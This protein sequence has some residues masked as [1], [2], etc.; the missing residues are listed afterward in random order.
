MLTPMVGYAATALGYVAARAGGPVSVHEIAAAT[1]IPGPYLA[2]ILHRLSRS[3]YVSA[4]RGIG[5]GVSLAIDP[6]S[7]TLLDLCRVLEDPIL[8]AQCLLGGGAC[9]DDRTCPAH[10]FQ[11]GIR[12]RQLDFLA[13]TTLHEIGVYDERRRVG[14][15]KTT[16]RA[17]SSRASTTGRKT[18]R[19]STR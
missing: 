9:S 17:R 19:R 3:G 1:S 4:Q 5:G 12:S 7:V 11:S 13:A 18:Q 2:K 16:R 8:R 10:E 14:A 15:A 6:K